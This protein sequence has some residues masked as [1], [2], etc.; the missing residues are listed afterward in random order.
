LKKKTKSSSRGKKSSGTKK[1][2][3]SIIGLLLILATIYYFYSTEQAQIRG[4]NFG[5]ELE[6]IQDELKTEQ[7]DFYSKISMW[8]EDTISK[9]QIL[10]YADSHIMKMNK[11]ISKYSDLQ[12]PDVFSG[13]V[14]LFKL[15]TETQLESDQYLIKWIKNGDNS[16][17]IR[18][19]ELL[20]ASFEYE[21]GALSSFEKAKRNPN[22]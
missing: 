3:I 7:S 20:Q 4:L 19:N 6:S 22:P 8:E 21:M 9:D 16:D 10:D 5:I 13:S 11:I 2:S 17:K 15:S 14:K 18:A 12:M 1:I